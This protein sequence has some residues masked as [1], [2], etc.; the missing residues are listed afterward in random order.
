MET[1]ILEIRD[2][3]TFIPALAVRLK[4][5]PMDHEEYPQE[6]YL[7]RRAG[8]GDE[9]IAKGTYVMLMRLI[10]GPAHYVYYNWEGQARTMPAAHHYIAENWDSIHDGAVIDIEYIHGETAAPK[11]SERFNETVAKIDPES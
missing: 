5:D 10:G 9:D 2:R 8:F 1:K 6:Y 3:A 7:M 11:H 4:I